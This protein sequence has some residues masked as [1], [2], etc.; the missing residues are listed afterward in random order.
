[1]FFSLHTACFAMLSSNVLV[2]AFTSNMLPNSSK[3]FVSKCL[4]SCFD[5][6]VGA[7]YKGMIAIMITITVKET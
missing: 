5:I 4:S 2:C 6:R 7:D 3:V 1:M